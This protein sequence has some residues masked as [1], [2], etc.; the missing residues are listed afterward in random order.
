MCVS[1]LPRRHCV[2]TY[3]AP[4]AQMKDTVLETLLIRGR[5]LV[6]A[7]AFR[8]RGRRPARTEQGTQHNER[9]VGEGREG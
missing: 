8:G 1:D 7:A 5:R 3:K 2:L 4:V 6:G 9:A